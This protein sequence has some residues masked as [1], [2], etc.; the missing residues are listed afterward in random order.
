MT[1]RRGG[2]DW[3]IGVMAQQGC[4]LN[5]PRHWQSVA[6]IK[7]QE[8]PNKLGATYFSY[9]C[10][11]DHWNVGMKVVCVND[12]FSS[13]IWDWGDQLPKKGGIYTVCKVLPCRDAYTGKCDIG[14]QFEELRNHGDRLAFSVW[15]FEPLE[16]VE[17]AVI[18]TDPQAA[19]DAQSR[20]IRELEEQNKAQC[21]EI[22]RL[23]EAKKK[24]AYNIEWMAENCRDF[25]A[26]EQA[27][28]DAADEAEARCAHELQMLEK[29]NRELDAENE[30]LAKERDTLQ[31]KVVELE[32]ICEQQKDTL[33]R[34]SE[35]MKRPLNTKG[36]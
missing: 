5:L 3:A 32:T 21:L 8:K 7:T 9:R 14:L 19:E 18:V 20:R 12:R 34:F 23:Q 11:N 17:G 22:E 2:W 27:V 16:K 10:M 6:G 4:F 24:L 35:T 31:M 13:G 36:C 33:Q 28:S 29:A 25:Q 1:S 26:S 30:L 15:R